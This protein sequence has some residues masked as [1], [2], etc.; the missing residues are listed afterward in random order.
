MDQRS[1]SIRTCNI[2]IANAI[3]NSHTILTTLQGRPVLL[4]TFHIPSI[5]KCYIAWSWEMQVTEKHRMCTHSVYILV[6][7]H[8]KAEWESAL[9][10]A[11]SKWV[12]GND[13]M[14]TSELLAISISCVWVGSCFTDR[15]TDTHSDAQHRSRGSAKTSIH[16][17]ITSPYYDS[18]TLH[19]P[20]PEKP[21]VA[22][23]SGSGPLMS[24]STWK[25]ES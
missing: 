16:V 25:G 2:Y 4:P 15:Q 8:T 10:K 18:C 21:I 19:S 6:K 1:D 14:W 20:K 5:R 23:S 12:C 22:V 13:E 17:S 9:S 7:A 11:N 24:A 3:A